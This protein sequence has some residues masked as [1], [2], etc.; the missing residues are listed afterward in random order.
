[1]NE[2]SQKMRLEVG[3]GKIIKTMVR[4]LDSFLKYENIGWHYVLKRSLAD[5]VANGDAGLRLEWLQ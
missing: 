2:K 3:R 1:M 5:P 4:N